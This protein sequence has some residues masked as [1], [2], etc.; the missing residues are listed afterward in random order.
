M[1]CL[2]VLAFPH[3]V[4]A[5]TISPYLIYMVGANIL[6]H[7][8]LTASEGSQKAFSAVG[9]TIPAHFR[10]RDPKQIRRLTF[11][12]GWFWSTL[13][14]MEGRKL[15]LCLADATCHCPRPHER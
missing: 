2:L 1:K 6:P 3:T 5:C 4:L 13:V 7:N 11:R 8:L 14:L 15:P 9:T 12:Q 10:V